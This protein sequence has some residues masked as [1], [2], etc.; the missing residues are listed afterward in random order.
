MGRFA[1]TP[2][3]KVNTLLRQLADF[4]AGRIDLITQAWI[5]AIDR[6][7]DIQSSEDITHAQLVD[8]LPALCQDLAERLRRGREQQSAGEVRHARIHGEHRWQQGYKLEEIIRETGLVRQIIAIDS[9]DAFAATMPAFHGPVRREAEAI[10][11]H[12]LNDILVD[13]AQQFASERQNA[14]EASEQ[15]SQAILDSALDSIIVIGEDGRVREFN[16]AAETMFGFKRAEAIGQELASLII[17]PQLRERHRQGLAHYLATGE[18]PLLGRRI[19]VPALRA[20]GAEI[21]VEL[22]IT[23]YRVEG[24][25]LFTAYLRDITERVQNEARRAAQYAIATLLSGQEPLEEIGPKILETIAGS[26]RWVFGS[27]WLLNG[28]GNLVCHSTWGRP[29]RPRPEFEAETRSRTFTSG[30]GLPGRVLATPRPIWIPDVVA[31]L[32]FPRAPVAAL[33]DLHGAFAF[34]LTAPDGI[35]GVIEIFSDVVVVSPDDDLLHLLDALGIQVGLYLQRK[36]TEEELRRRKEVAEA[37]NQAKDRFLAALSHEL[38]TPLN[39]VLMWACA[40]VEDEKLDP[41]FKEGL[42]MICRNVELEARLI[43]DLLDLTRISRGKLQ[44]NLQPCSADELMQHALEIV[45]SQ[46]AGKNLQVTL[47]LAASNHLIMADPTRIQQVFWNVLKNATKFTPENGR[48]SIRSHDSGPEVVEFEISDTGC[49]MDP[50]VMPKLF[51]AFEQGG[52]GGE[53]L[54]LGLAICK[55]ILELH[56]ARIT[57]SNQ[58]S[59]PGAVFT[60]QFNT[61]AVPMEEG[62]PAETPPAPPWRK[63]RILVVEDH[64]YTATVM[65]RLLEREGHEVKTAATVRAA[66]DI[67]QS[68]QLDLLVSDLG[69]PDGNGFQVMRELAKISKAKGIAVS[70]Y[71]MEDDLERSSLAGFSAHLTKPINVQELQETI[72]LVTSER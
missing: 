64:E 34:P 39:P 15:N 66:L 50:D 41:A 2:A 11:H 42:R 1:A 29:D 37:A 10:I 26:G 60:I 49:G 36:Q 62:R 16:P 55:A 57:A 20:D 5:L 4:I 8:H 67:L 31:D 72:Q 7:P 3:R 56:G 38:R 17:P 58:A 54:G 63:L 33:S 65:S 12:F 25:P 61:A 24:R 47:D 53:G 48:I 69:L 13:S 52:G 32:N 19:E 59:G 22:A 46:I 45:Q 43:D 44:L 27:L 35:K 6:Q 68:T 51:T 71:G 70:G 21:Q 23:P 28:E 9:L 30:E 14:L 40:T 18:G